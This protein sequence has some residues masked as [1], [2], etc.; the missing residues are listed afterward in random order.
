MQRAPE[1][2]LHF[3]AIELPKGCWESNLVNSRMVQAGDSLFVFCSDLYNPL[4]VWQIDK[5]DSAE[6]R[7]TQLPTLKRRV[8]KY[9]IATYREQKVYITGGQKGNQKLVSVFN[10]VKKQWSEAPSLNM[11]TEH[12]AS[13]FIGK[14]LYVFGGMITPHII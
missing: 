5:V 9:A 4:Q 7:F 3:K 6:P 12:H 2:S 1:K 14:K 11:A 10:L 8:T 13:C